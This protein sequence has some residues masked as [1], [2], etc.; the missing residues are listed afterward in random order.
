MNEVAHIIKVE[1]LRDYVYRLTYRDGFV[2]DYDFEPLLNGRMSNALC[3]I[4]VFKQV[5]IDQGGGLEWPNGYDI[6][7]DLLR[8]HLEPASAKDGVLS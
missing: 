6:C 2:D 8:Y 7:P 4:T 1:Y 3:D 5:R